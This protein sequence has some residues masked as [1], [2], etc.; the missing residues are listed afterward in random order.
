[1]RMLYNMF[2][3]HR[4]TLNC[5]LFRCPGHRANACA[6]FTVIAIFK[7]PLVTCC[8]QLLYIYLLF[9]EMR[10]VLYLQW[11]YTHPHSMLEFYEQ[12]I[13]RDRESCQR[14]DHED[15]Y[16]PHLVLIHMDVCH[17]IAVSIVQNFAC[18]I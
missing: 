3:P 5:S 13:Y 2:C 15:V 18:V 14:V 8:S 16:P 1:M 11:V 9:V 10:M 4:R 17:T 12:I 7:Q 6:F